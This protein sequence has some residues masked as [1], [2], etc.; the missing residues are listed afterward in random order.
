MADRVIHLS[1]GTISEV[2]VNASK[3]SP[4]ELHW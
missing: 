4:H 3:K 2:T 1:N